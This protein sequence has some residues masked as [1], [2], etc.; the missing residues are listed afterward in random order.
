MIMEAGDAT[1]QSMAEAALD[2]IARVKLWSKEDDSFEADCDSLYNMAVTNRLQEKP[3]RRQTGCFKAL[4]NEQELLYAQNYL[5][6]CLIMTRKL[7]M[8]LLYK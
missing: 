3:E 1:V 7:W 5:I 8:W 6:V 2:D 4:Y